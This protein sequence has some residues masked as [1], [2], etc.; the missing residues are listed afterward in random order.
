MSDLKSWLLAENP[1]SRRQAAFGRAYL[2]WRR[3]FYNP[4]AMIGFVIVSVLLLLAIFAPL[5]A[6]EGITSGLTGDALKANR[7]LPPSSD[8]WFGTDGQANDVFSRI[9]MGSRITLI[10]S[11]IH[12]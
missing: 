6:P 4:L 12:I 10:L 5:I 2:G 11:L 1:E 8:H 7:F 3:F 9:V